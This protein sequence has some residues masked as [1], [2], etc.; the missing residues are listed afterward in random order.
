MAKILAAIHIS[1]GVGFV[2]VVVVT[3]TVTVYLECRLIQSLIRSP[4]KA[5]GKI[6]HKLWMKTE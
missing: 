6:A 5:Y 1:V 3:V 2:V 4:L